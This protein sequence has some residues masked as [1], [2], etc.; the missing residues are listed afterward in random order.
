MRVSRARFGPGKRGISEVKSHSV[1]EA[2]VQGDGGAVVADLT[3]YIDTADWPPGTRLVVR[4]E[5]RHTTATTNHPAGQPHAPPHQPHTP[6]NT[7]PHPKTTSKH[8]TNTQHPAQRPQQE[9]PTQP[10]S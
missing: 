2:R 3:D 10:L 7:P 5:P 1:R 8:P 9:P 4:R 6:N